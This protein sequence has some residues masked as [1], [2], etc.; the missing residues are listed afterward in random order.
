MKKYSLLLF[1]F[2]IHL[3]VFSQGEGN[4]WYFG[5][6]A[7][8]D[9]SS[10]SPVA[11]VNG[12]LSTWEGCS[13]VSDKN[14]NLLFYTDGG[15]VYTRNHTIMPNGAGLLGNSS[16]T[17]SAMIVKKP[18][19]DTLYYLFTTPAVSTGGLYYSQVNLNLN[20]GLGDVVTSTK[21]T[22]LLPV[23]GERVTAT[24]HRNGIYTW[25]ITKVTNTNSYYAYLIDCNGI[26]TP[27]ITSIG[28]NAPGNNAGSTVASPDSKKI[29]STFFSSSNGIEIL[30][31]DNATG[32]LSNP[33]TQALG[34]YPYG[35][36]FSPNSTLFYYT[37]IS[38]G[39]IT[40]LNLN[41]GNGSSTDV[42]ASSTVIGNVPHI[43]ISN[44]RCGA[45]QLAP[46]SKMYVAENGQLNIAVI[47]NPNVVGAGCN[48]TLDAVSLNGKQC[49]LGLPA[50]FLNF[51]DTV[52]IDYTNACVNL[53]VLLSVHGDSSALDSVKWNFGDIASGNDNFST[54]F[55][56]QH[57]YA[58]TGNY[59]IQ[60]IRYFLCG[61]DT[62]TRTITISPNNLD[63]T[64]TGNDS[65]CTTQQLQ[66]TTGAATEYRWFGPNNFL[67]TVQ[68]IS[69]TNFSAPGTY[70]VTIKDDNGCIDSST[71]TVTLL[72][73][74][75]AIANSNN[76][77]AIGDSIHLATDTTN[78][79]TW[80][81][82]NTFSS[83]QQYP[84][85][86]NAQLSNGGTYQVI[87]TNSYGCS[88]TAEVTVT[89]YQPEIPDN[90]IDDDNDGLIDCADPDLATLQQCYKCG[91][92]SIAWAAVIPESGFN[93]GIA[94]KYTGFEQ[95][96]IVPAGVTSIKIK[97]WGAGGGGGYSGMCDFAAGAGGYSIDQLTTVAGETYIVVTGEG[98][99]ATRHINQTARATF[100]GGGSG[101][102]IGASATAEVGSGG[103]LSG[104]FISTV[105]QANAR[106]IAGGGG[107]IGDADGFDPTSGGNGNN[108]LAG[109]YLPLTG[110]NASANSTGFGGGGGGYVGG[111]SGIGR[112][113]CNIQL[114]ETADDGGEGGSG[115]VFTSGGQIKFTP[116][117]NIYPPD[118]ADIH[119]IEG[120][121]VGNDYNMTIGAIGDVKAG[122]NGLVVIQWFQPTDDLTITASK[123]TLCNGDTLTLTASGNYTYTW[124]PA[125]LLNSD[126]A[127]TVIA[128]PVADTTFQVV[129][130]NNNCLD[131]AQ[132]DIIVNPL[133]IIALGSTSVCQGISTTFTDSST[134]TGATISNWYWNYGD[135][136]PIVTQ[137][138]PTHQYDTCGTYNVQLKVATNHGCTDSTTK[139]VIIHCLPIVDAGLNDTI[140]FGESTTLNVT[141]T[142]SS[143]IYSWNQPSSANFSTISNP[144]VNPISTTTYTVIVTDT[145][146]CTTTDSITIY[147]DTQ[148]LPFLTVAN[149][150]CNAACNGKIGANTVIGGVA[151][152]QYSW[153]ATGC[154]T[155]SCTNLCPGSYSVTIT[156]TWGCTA[157]AD[158]AI[159][160]PSALLAFINTFTP[161][162]C[163]NSC[164]GTASISASGG[165]ASYTYHWN[166][167]PA[168]TTA[169]A[170]SLCAGTYI[171]TITDNNLCIA[172][173]TVDITSPTAITLIPT[174]TPTKC[175]TPTGAASVTAIGGTPG[176]SYLWSLDGQ[177][178]SN[179]DSLAAGTYTITVTDTNSCTATLSVVITPIN[180][181]TATI[182]ALSNSILSG[183]TVV[184]TATGNG[185]LSWFPST[186]LNC[187]SCQIVTAEPA[188]T[189]EYCVIVTDT[190]SCKDTACTT[191]SVEY[192]CGNE[193]IVP[194]AFSPNNDGHNDLL[195]LHGWDKCVS[196]FSMIIFNRWGQKVFETNNPLTSWD[197]TYKQGEA[198]LGSNKELNSA[199]FVY[200]VNATLF[201]GEKIN[202]KGNIT[203]I[204]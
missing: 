101:N 104:L 169:T 41:A 142:G 70:S 186:T 67:D 106:V 33:I 185:S 100:G 198:A 61:A 29:A 132:I 35:A 90:G 74:P 103:G 113:S 40:Q 141:P 167:L 173:D 195:V 22:N 82:P 55:A 30:D 25:V 168:Q 174:T 125:P 137:P 46:D 192:L 60:L 66:L 154:T 6:N 147:A 134:V 184:L 203:V 158:T 23:V 69:I 175:N 37:D 181:P 8:L 4:H 31:F 112:F 57:I 73:T 19:T 89:V 150:T 190:N 97:A 102:S 176:Y 172:K 179:I 165:V 115:F 194:T 146:S 199:V 170:D 20:G 68:T 51:I 163:N 49:G 2:F 120:I 202:R 86:A 13:S 178:T 107:G 197:G 75:T 201:S 45:L 50:F 15:S 94:I 155:D 108:P 11:D 164:D 143:Y 80:S 145:N 88:D 117:L 183:N 18:G 3:I 189:T 162:S 156:D 72:P 127:K 191:I 92:D 131:T 124:T 188:E 122:G 21:N 12:A 149:V 78:G 39:N 160:E 204:R 159:T 161:T 182:V 193:L 5:F 14:G 62:N 96:F 43:G 157:N 76:P 133:P 24:K 42:L 17:Q 26:N 105:N 114:P 128:S 59:T 177:T 48:F 81:G 7:G 135:N 187:D 171:C 111:I 83:T 180:G 110:Q 136:T 87:K 126:T 118:T 71:T 91:Y 166:S 44:F 53:P 200:Y 93:R 123:T 129:S 84:H 65:V 56:P 151:P 148:I 130:N 99:W 140:C 52:V 58:T 16:S 119:Y 1:Y 47:N 153:T 64:I 109:G 85:I 9:F 32:I 95:H 116:E 34:G 54:D 144:S 121:G 77:V 36:C 139:S 27:V 152:Y 98:G 79:I 38:G 138:S 196:E 10:G 28:L 63:A